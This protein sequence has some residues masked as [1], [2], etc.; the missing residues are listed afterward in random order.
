MGRGEA[1]VTESGDR[2]QPRFPNPA[3][4]PPRSPFLGE[5]SDPPRGNGRF[6]YRGDILPQPLRPFLCIITSSSHLSYRITI[7][8]VHIRVP[9]KA[10]SSGLSARV[11]RR[12]RGRPRLRVQSPLV[13]HLGPVPESPRTQKPGRRDRARGLL[14]SSH[15]TFV[16]RPARKPVSRVLL[17]RRSRWSSHRGPSR[18]TR[19]RPA[20]ACARA[21]P[22]PARP[23]ASR[24]APPHHTAGRPGTSQT[25]PAKPQNCGAKTG[26]KRIPE[27][28]PAYGASCS[29]A[30]RGPAGPQPR[31]QDAASGGSLL[32]LRAPPQTAAAGPRARAQAAG[33]FARD[34]QQ[35]RT[36]ALQTASWP[37]VPAAPNAPGRAASVHASKGGA[38][39]RRTGWT[40]P[41]SRP[42]RPAAVAGG[43]RGHWSLQR[44][45]KRHDQTP[46]HEMGSRGRAARGS[47]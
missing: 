2:S 19:A 32:L 14:A 1:H 3:A 27:R 7:L 44:R 29:E 26:T 5:G 16:K 43:A 41:R 9:S 40:C 45:R 36:R 22:G 11:T 25:A 23:P 38:R 13:I 31:S 30:E 8:R 18:T 12:R 47:G 35:T 28:T 33:E 34:T 24:A 10:A 4:K 21:P 37:V 15:D 46:V 20:H 42:G 17:L 6:A 39:D